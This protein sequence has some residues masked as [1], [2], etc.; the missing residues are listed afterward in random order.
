ME[1]PL[2]GTGKS[3]RI[4][5]WIEI[6]WE[7]ITATA[8]MR[9]MVTTATN[10]HEKWMPIENTSLTWILWYKFTCCCYYRVV[11]LFLVNRLPESVYI[12]MNWIQSFFSLRFNRVCVGRW[13]CGSV[14]N[15]LY[16]RRLMNKGRK[17]NSFRMCRRL[18]DDEEQFRSSV[19]WRQRRNFIL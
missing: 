12:H 15:H 18:R 9:G 4:V 3:M 1:K 2:P 7:S 13:K 5:H 16:E 19:M 14:Q 8:A 6:K 11:S 17:K 10:I